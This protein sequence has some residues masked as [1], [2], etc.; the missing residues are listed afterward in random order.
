[1]V[2]IVKD[3][4]NASSAG[5]LAGVGTVENNVLHGF[6]TQL[7]SF[8]FTQNPAARIHDVGFSATIGADNTDQLPRQDKVGGFCKGFES[9]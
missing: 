6:T 4:F 7:G 9:R 3:Q 1:M 5:G 8:G 2:S